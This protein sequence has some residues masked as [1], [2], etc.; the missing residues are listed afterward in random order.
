MAC[1]QGQYGG[2]LSSSY[3]RFIAPAPEDLGP[4]MFGQHTQFFGGPGLADARLTGQ[5]YQPPSPGHGFRHVRFQFGQLGLAANEDTG[6]AARGIGL[7]YGA[8]AA[9]RII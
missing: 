7:Y 8:A 9:I 6:Y 2:T 1:T 4:L 5:H 3:H